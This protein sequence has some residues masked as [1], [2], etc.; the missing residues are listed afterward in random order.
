MLLPHYLLLTVD[1][2]HLLKGAHKFV[3]PGTPVVHCTFLPGVLA[4]TLS[5]YAGNAAPQ[6]AGGT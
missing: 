6:R 3:L 2:Y 1:W 4:N 5:L